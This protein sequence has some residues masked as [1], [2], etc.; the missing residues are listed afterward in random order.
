MCEATEFDGEPPAL[1]MLTRQFALTEFERDIIVWCSAVALDPTNNHTMTFRDAIVALGGGHLDAISPSSTLRRFRLVIVAGDDPF[2]S[3]LVIDE[4]V[5][6]YLLG[7]DAVDERLSPHLTRSRALG[8]IS[9]SQRESSERLGKQLLTASPGLVVQVFGASA[10]ERAAIIDAAVT[11]LGLDVLRIRGASLPSH[12]SDIEPL[13]RSLERELL[14]S[15]SLLVVEVDDARHQS[16]VENIAELSRICFVVST[17]ELLALQLVV[18]QV[19]I[20]PATRSEQKQVWREALGADAD[21]LEETSERLAHHFDLQ[22]SQIETVVSE[23]RATNLELSRA[24]WRCASRLIRPRLAGLVTVV[25][26]RLTWRDL[27]VS[28]PV[29]EML[30]EICDQLLYRHR[31][32]DNWG[33]APDGRGTAITALFYGTSGTG[34]TLAAEVIANETGLDLY[35]VDLSQVVDKYVGET[36]KRLHRIFEAA[37]RSGAVLLFDEADALFGKRGEVEAAR[38]RWANM[39]VSY[40]L[41]RIE[42]YRGLAILTTNM[43]DAIDQAFVRRMRFA[44]PFNFPDI[45]LRREIWRRVFPAE[46]PVSTIDTAKLARLQLTGANIRGVALRAAFFAAKENSSIMTKHVIRAARTEF[47]KLDK[48][49]PEA[50]VKGWGES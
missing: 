31:V 1:V 20:R 45:D 39:E 15:G 6:Y 35:H 32:H 13:V 50:E 23:A 3:P 40:L 41:Q 26:P 36:E 7:I 16:Q 30:R 25:E 17:S 29:E 22:S 44:I 8:R 46:A 4:R 38:D 24:I 12:L 18:A 27:V 10:S 34:K 47:A 21:N 28:T 5:L 48:P 42:A 49:F 37:D 11:E 33:L 19:E 14:L 2:G 43:K 9:P